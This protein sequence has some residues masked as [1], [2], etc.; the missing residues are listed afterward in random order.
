MLDNILNELRTPVF[1]INENNNIIY[2]NEIGEEFF[3]HSANLII[4]NSIYNLIQKDSP[5]SNLLTRVRKFKHGLTEESLDFSNIN[6]PNRKVRAHLVP[7]SFNSNQIIIQLSELTVSQMFQSQRINSKISKSFS[8]MID[9]LMH[10]LKNPL[11][12][13]KGA[14]QLIESDLKSYDNIK[15]LTNLIN[16]ESDRIVSLLNRMEQ[17]NNND[18]TTDLQFLNVHKIL[19]HCTQVAKNSFGLNIKF[20]E[21]FDPSLPDFYANKDLL[22]QILL[23]MLKNSCEASRN[24]QKIIIKTSFNSDKK[25]SFSHEEIPISLPLQLEIIDHGEGIPENLLPNIF[26]PFVSSKKKGK[27]L[28]L[29]VVASGLNDMGAVID[30]SSSPGLTNFCIN[31][32]L[33]K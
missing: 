19:N 18:V 5:I 22:I 28:G 32:P 29:S 10:E 9:M 14:A 21:Y 24:N 16:I 3:G 11:A 17:I 2:L 33:K 31:F 7:L 8:A 4:G 12:G 25:I 20:I 15:E 30:V 1:L 23:N 27:G 6:F 13:I 26:D